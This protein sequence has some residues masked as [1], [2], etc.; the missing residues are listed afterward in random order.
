[1]RVSQHPGVRRAT[2]FV[3][4]RRVPNSSDL[5][6]FS[7]GSDVGALESQ[8]GDRFPFLRDVCTFPSK[9]SNRSAKST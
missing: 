7:W 9:R 3:D 6:R 8:F 2:G 5:K 4:N 1:M